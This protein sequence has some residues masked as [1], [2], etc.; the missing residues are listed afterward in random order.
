MQVLLFNAVCC[1]GL[2]QLTDQPLHW[3]ADVICGSYQTG[4]GHFLE[5]ELVCSCVL[6]G[7]STLY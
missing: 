3:C 4:S 7:S 1:Q 5:S 2:P 6:V